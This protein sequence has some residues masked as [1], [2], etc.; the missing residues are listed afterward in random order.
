[1]PSL[2]PI[3]V[4]LAALV[5]ATGVIIV[6][7]RKSSTFSG[8]SDVAADAQRIQRAI[9]GESFRDGNDLVLSGS[10]DKLPVQVR[11]SYDENTPGLSIRMSAPANFTL[12]IT[13]KGSQAAGEGKNLVRTGDDMF[14]ARFTTKSDHLAQA[15][16]FV[17]GKQAHILM[18]KLACSTKTFVAIGKGF[19]ELSEL[20]IPSPYASAHIVDHIQSMSKLALQLQAMPGAETVKIEPYKR[21]GS[22][23]L[24]KA[25][26]L[27]ALLGGLAFFVIEARK[28]DTS[29]AELKAQAG[30]SSLPEGVLP[31]DALKL[32]SLDGWRL[33]TTDD[34]DPDT[35]AWARGQG[36]KIAG[37]LEGDFSGKGNPRDVAYIF[38]DG[39]DT[40]R[41]AVIADDQ[42]VSDVHYPK[43]A[44]AARY[45]KYNWNSTQWVTPPA[46]PS[47]DG[48]LIVTRKEDPKSGMVL[49]FNGKRIDNAIPQNYQRVNLQ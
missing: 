25:A 1:M 34:F 42:L 43:L 30:L 23:V 16:M 20:V 44:V 45:S 21:E 37:R 26:V 29:L 48:I 6:M 17:G 11:F 33:V 8:Y 19:I 38:T 41:I 31:L 40:T 49:F 14:D 24:G 22:S 36:I 15:K 4:V 28:P 35:A 5:L 13:P 9:K 32:G 27:V 18:Q 47:G 7:I 12:T 10:Q 39:A 46:T 2:D 3:F